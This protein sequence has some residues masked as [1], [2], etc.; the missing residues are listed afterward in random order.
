MET[1]SIGCRLPN[2]LRLEV[3]FSVND[4]GKG[5][6]PFAL[7]RKHETYQAHTLKGT[8]QQLIVRDPRGKALAMLP[9]QMNREPV[10]NH[11]VPKD[12]WDQW[13]KDN[14]KSWHLKS[15]QI[16][17]VPKPD[18]S[19]VKAVSLDAKAKSAP[20]FE[21]IDPSKTMKLEDHSVSRRED[22]DE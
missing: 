7:Y 18:S 12:L 21:P 4:A 19:T 22:D 5:G 3:G 17:L 2:G 20:V 16:F 13:C 8:N 1:V 10:I 14:P 9:N 15:G 6:A 11:G